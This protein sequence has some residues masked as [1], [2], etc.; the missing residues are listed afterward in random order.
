MRLQLAC[1]QTARSGKTIACGGRKATYA[2]QG[3]VQRR[4]RVSSKSTRGMIFATPPRNI[5][6]AMENH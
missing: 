6:A 1:R 5:N 4:L 3:S 2:Q